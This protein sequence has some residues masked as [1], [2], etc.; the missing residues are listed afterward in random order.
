MTLLA[1]RPFENAL[2][3][4]PGTFFEDMVC[5]LPVVP[6]VLNTRYP[7]KGPHYRDSPAYDTTH[8]TLPLHSAI[9]TF[10]TIHY[11]HRHNNRPIVWRRNHDFPL[12]FIDTDNFSQHH[13]INTN[14][15]TDRGYLDWA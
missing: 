15:T 1:S 6:D 8:C 2:T 5:H 3:L 14:T 4:S 13:S 11:S 12:I 9:I 7:E 10:E